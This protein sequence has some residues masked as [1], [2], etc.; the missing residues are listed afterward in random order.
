MAEV[1]A[2]F[3]VATRTVKR[4]IARYALGGFGNLQDRRRTGRPRQGTAEHAGWIYAVVVDKTPEHGHFE[5][6]LGTAQRVRQAWLD[7]CGLVFGL[8]PGRRSLRRLGLPP[9]RT[10]RRACRSRPGH[11]RRWQER[12]FPAIAQRA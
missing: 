2:S 9:Q 3:S 1:A 7:R 10:Q 12:E 5:Y 8:R 6:A 4:W 11:G